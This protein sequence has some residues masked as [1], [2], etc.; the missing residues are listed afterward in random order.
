MQGDRPRDGRGGDEP[1]WSN[2][3]HCRVLSQEGSGSGGG[4]IH[5]ITEKHL[6]LI[7]VRANPGCGILAPSQKLELPIEGESEKI[8]IVLGK[9]RHKELPNTAQMVL[10]DVIKDIL[11]ENPKPSLTFYNRAGPVS[12][13]FHAFQLLPGIGVKKAKKMMQSRTSMGWFSFE[14]VDEACEIDSLQLISE[15][16]VEE[17]EDP[18]IVPSLIQNVVRVA[19]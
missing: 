19:E 1:D 10:L 17:L 11:T 18:K 9:G 13:K 12:L 6:H 5:C 4:V 7:K 15:R 3:T 14:E 2:E 16:L 8:S